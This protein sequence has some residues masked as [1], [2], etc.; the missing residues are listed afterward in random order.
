M[1]KALASGRL[2]PRTNDPIVRQIVDRCHVADSNRSVIRYVKSRTKK[3]AWEKLSRAKRKRLMRQIVWQ[4][5]NN[6]K[7]YVEVMSGCQGDRGM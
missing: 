4:H 1:K 3:G 2:K 6:L 5:R 7:Q